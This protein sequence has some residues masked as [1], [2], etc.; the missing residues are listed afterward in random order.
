M[1]NQQY[2]FAFCGGCGEY[3]HVAAVFDFE[4]FAQFCDCEWKV[5]RSYIGFLYAYQRLAQLALVERCD[6]LYAEGSAWEAVDG[7]LCEEEVAVAADGRH[8]VGC[9]KLVE[10]ARFH[11]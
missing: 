7:L 11:D 5:A 2:M 1:R 10:A 8:A 3:I 6:A 4:A 9:G